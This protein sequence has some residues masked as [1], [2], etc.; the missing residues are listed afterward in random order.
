M[1]NGSYTREKAEAAIRSGHADMISF[2]RPFI[3]SPD[4]V[5]RFLNDWPLNPPADQKIW[6][7][8]G[9]TGY[10]DFPGHEDPVGP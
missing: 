1:G 5:E 8:S 4:L 7:S 9:P 2:G 6:Y 3:S 10:I